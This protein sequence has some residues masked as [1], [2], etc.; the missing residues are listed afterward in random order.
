MLRYLLKHFSPAFR[1]YTLAKL[2]SEVG[3][4]GLLDWVFVFLCGWEIID[5]VWSIFACIEVTSPRLGVNSR[6]GATPMQ[7]KWINLDLR[8]LVV[9]LPMKVH[10][11]LRWSFEILYPA[12]SFQDSVHKVLGVCVAGPLFLDPGWLVE[13]ISGAFYQCVVLLYQLRI[14]IFPCHLLITALM[15]S[16][17]FFLCHLQRRQFDMPDHGG[18]KSTACRSSASEYVPIRKRGEKGAKAKKVG[19]ILFHII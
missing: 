5:E 10:R 14:T 1:D 13:C 9:C 12:K 19:D 2:G 7:A 4:S 17:F 8:K 6:G 3:E 16:C 11:I 15:L 18:K